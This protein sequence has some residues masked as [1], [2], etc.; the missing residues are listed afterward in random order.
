MSEV[1]EAIQSLHEADEADKPLIR[2]FWKTKV[3]QIATGVHDIQQL[4][5]RDRTGEPNAIDRH[6]LGLPE[7]TMADDED[8]IRDSVV[9]A[10][11]VTLHQPEQQ[12]QSKVSRLPNGGKVAAGVLGAGTLVAA[13]ILASQWLRPGGDTTIN[14]LRPETDT[15]MSVTTGPPPE[16]E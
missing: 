8:T 1:S 13:S 2:K 16:N 7:K 3:A 9:I 15:V 4:L 14:P 5:K 12:K 6:I 11:N 10:D